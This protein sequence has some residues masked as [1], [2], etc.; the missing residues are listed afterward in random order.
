MEGFLLLIRENLTLV[1]VHI[2]YLLST[3]LAIPLEHIYK[4]LFHPPNKV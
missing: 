1:G 2:L 4:N 3:I